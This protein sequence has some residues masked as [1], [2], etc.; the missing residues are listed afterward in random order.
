MGWCA[1][2]AARCREDYR[3]IAAFGA[4][5]HTVVAICANGSYYKAAAYL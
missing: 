1:L 2:R 3:C 4:D 5:P